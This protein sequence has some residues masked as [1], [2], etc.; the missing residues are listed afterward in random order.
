[1]ETKEKKKFI[2][3]LPQYE[4]YKLIEVFYQSLTDM[5]CMTMICQNC[6]K[7]ICNI[8]IV[9]NS[10]GKRFE[11]GLD[12]AGTLTNLQNQWEYM[13]DLE[14]FQDAINQGKQARAAI[15]KCLK[16]KP[17]VKLKCKSFININNY[18]KEI[19]SG[20]YELDRERGPS[21]GYHSYPKE[22]WQ[23]IVFPYIKDLIEVNRFV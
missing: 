13:M 14:R 10:Q 5:D 1:M 11:V 4:S 12:C 21:A 7:L 17:D 8:A 16:N 22:I 15:M 6:Q 23:R 9:E 19:G 18:F 20:C 3:K 2:G